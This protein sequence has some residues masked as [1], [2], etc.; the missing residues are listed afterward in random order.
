MD[1]VWQVRAARSALKALEAEILRTH[2]SGCVRQAFGAK[3]RI[4]AQEKI[5][6]IIELLSKEQ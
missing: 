4:A 5:D 1:I 2:L 6:E 3:D